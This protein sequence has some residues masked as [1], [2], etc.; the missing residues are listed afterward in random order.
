MA[1]RTARLNVFGRR[2][3]GDA[4]RDRRLAG[5]QGGRGAG[6]QPDDRPQ[7][8]RQVSGRGLA[9][10]RGPQLAAAPLAAP[11]PARAGR[12]D[13]GSRVDRR[14]G[15]HRLGPLTGHPRSTVYAVLA[16]SGYSRLR[17]ADRLS[18][19][20]IRYVHER[21]GRARPPGPQEARPDPRRRRPPDARSGARPARP[22]TGSWLRPLRGR[23]RRRHPAR[24]RRPRARRERREREPGPRSTRRSGSPSRASG[25][26]AS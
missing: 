2:A 17:D 15:P 1:H 16:R 3:A 24:L 5:R 13:P 8:G 7:V 14:W 9:G 23:R 11:D 21:P 25:S 12:G 19:V 26:S 10:A 20:P 6:R 4:H 18:G 22:W